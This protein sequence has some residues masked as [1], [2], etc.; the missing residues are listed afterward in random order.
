M[1]VT[2][3]EIGDF[4]GDPDGRIDLLIGDGSVKK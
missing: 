3:L 1:D 2:H 4:F